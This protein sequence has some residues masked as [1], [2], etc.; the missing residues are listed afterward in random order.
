MR[1]QSVTLAAFAAFAALALGVAACSP[2]KEDKAETAGD[3]VQEEAAQVFRHRRR[4]ERS[5]PGGR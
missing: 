2:A 3:V 4:R 1:I 5:R